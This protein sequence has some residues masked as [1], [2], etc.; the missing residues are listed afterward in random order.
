MICIRQSAE[1]KSETTKVSKV[2]LDKLGNMKIPN[3]LGMQ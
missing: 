2:N 3:R 1:N